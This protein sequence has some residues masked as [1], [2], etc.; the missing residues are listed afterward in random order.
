MIYFGTDEVKRGW[1]RYFDLCNALEVRNEASPDADPSISTLNTWRTKSPKG[2]AFVVHSDREIAT[3]LQAGYEN[4]ETELSAN[5]ADAWE[6]TVARAKA[7]S[8]KAIIIET[9]AD[10]RPSEN[11]RTL[12]EKVGAFVSTQKTA[13]I[14]ERHGLW[15]TEETI[16]LS[17]RS[18]LVPCFD[19]FI[20]D[21]DD[22]KPQKG[23]DVCFRITERAASRRQFDEYDF[24]TL[25]RWCATYNRAFVLFNGRHKHLH[26]KVMSLI[27]REL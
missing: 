6:R 12:I 15:G 19:P 27:T 2:F 20:A 8:A 11:S 18:G 4:N 1:E 25:V 17:R 3:M 5:F 9:S 13:V 21:A 7:L 23:N 16:E 26:A 22:I 10:F 14:W 24:E